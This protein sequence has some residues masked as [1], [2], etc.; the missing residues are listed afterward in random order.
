VIDIMPELRSLLIP[1]ISDGISTYLPL[2]AGP[3]S[4]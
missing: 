3:V 4:I 2:A 1:F